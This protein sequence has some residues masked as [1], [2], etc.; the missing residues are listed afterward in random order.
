MKKI[1]LAL[2]ALLPALRSTAQVTIAYHENFETADSVVSSGLPTWQ[3]ETAYFSPPGVKSYR[4]TVGTATTPY[5]T[6]T[7]FSTVGNTFILFDFDQICK[8][9]FNDAATIE[10][11]NDNGVTW[12]QLTYNEYLGTAPFQ[13][14]GNRFASSAYAIWFP[15]NNYAT[16]FNTWWKHEQ[17]DCSSL[18]ANAAQCKIRFKLQDV[19]LNGNNH[20]YGWMLDNLVVTQSPSELTPPVITPLNPVFAGN[21]YNLGPYTVNDSITDASGIDSARLFWTLNNGPQQSMSMSNVSGNHWQG[22]IPAASDSD[23]ICYHVQAWDASPAANTAVWPNSGCTQ[24]VVHAGITFPFVDNFDGPTLF[25]DTNL[26][27]MSTSIWQLGTPN[28][29]ATNSA[30]TAPNAWDVDLNT[31]YN[32]NTNCA[33]VSPVFDFSSTVNAKMSFWQNRNCEGYWDGTRVEYTLDGGVTWNVL[34]TVG[35]PL[36]TNW[37]TNTALASSNLPGWDGNSNG[38]LKSEYKLSA[39]NNNANPVQ[40]RFVFTS[41]A[42]VTYDGFSIDDFQIIPAFPQDAATDMVI[43]PDMSSCLPVGTYPISVQISNPGSDTIVGPMDI[44]YVLD[45]GTPVTEQYLGTLLPSQVDTFTFA[46]QLTSSAGVHTLQ[47]YTALTGD[48][49]LAN[50]TITATYTTAPGVNVPYVNNF[51]NGPISLND[52]CTTNTSQ[53]RVQMVAGAGNNS[54]TG[55]AFDATS[56]LG[57]DFGTDTI[58]TSPMYIWNPAN[59]DQNEAN[60]RLIVNTAGYNSLVLEFDA[61]LLYQWANEYTNFRVKVNGQMI[62]PHMMPANA[63]TPYTTY[64]YM[65]SSFLP[66]PFLIIDFES[67]VTY[68]IA[69]Y[70]T[71]IYL[72][73]VHIYK[74]DSLDVGV[75]QITQPT[76][77]SIAASANT[78]A[79]KIRNFGISTITSIPVGYQVGVSAPVIET[80][81]GSL[82]PNATTT[83]TFTTTYSSPAG[84]YNLCTWTQLVGDTDTWNDSLCGSYFG[85][86][87]Y[88]APWSDNFDGPQHFAAVTTYTPSWELGNPQAPDIAGT[89][90]GPNAWEINLNGPYAFNSHEYLYSPFFNFQ[91][92]TNCELRFWQW[93]SCDTYYDGGR[94]EYSTDGG[95]TWL[96]LGIYMDPN[97]T[98]WYN[99]SWLSSANGQPGWSGNGGGYFQSK[100]NLSMFDNYPNPVQF[101]FVFTSDQ[102]N[103]GLDDGWAI[104]DFELYVP[105]DAGTNTITFGNAS[106]LPMPGNDNVKVNIKNAG[107]LPLNYVKATLKIDNTIVVTD[108]IPY[109][110]PLAPGASA[111]HT[112]SLPWTGATPGLHTVKTW[113]SVPDGLMDTNTSNDTTAWTVSVMDTFATYP[114]CNTFETG[115]GIPPLTTMNATRFVNAHNDWAQGTPAKNIMTSAHG[116]SSCWITNLNLNYLRND[117]AGLFLPVFT[118]DTIHCYHLEFYYRSLTEANHDGMQVEYSFDLG[119]TWQRLGMMGDLNWYT[120][121]NCPGLGAGYEPSMQGTSNGWILAQHDIRFSQAGQLIFRLRFGSD[122]GLESEGI[123]VD[124]ICF[125]Q[126]PPCV[127]SVED[128]QLGDGLAMDNYP[129]PAGTT[130]HVVYNL[131]DNGKVQIA[132]YDVV[133][134]RIQAMEAE[135]F[136]GENTW[137]VDVS[138]LTDGVYFY[139]LTF[140]TQKIVQKVVI[141]H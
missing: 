8:I 49:W 56:S 82:A 81:T 138:N 35:D 123:A 4:D 34:G 98:A 6:T 10:V 101:R 83:Y 41:D 90:S 67:K 21:V 39:F 80:W 79:V 9:E 51:E 86:P 17:F 134:Q 136:K 44:T 3:Y 61:E 42:S 75:T 72:D 128:H 20:N 33:L 26:T 137:T 118:V 29:G 46:T 140:G 91:N 132:L 13:S 15:G 135:Q 113:T 36:A 94:V 97:G 52:F 58:P 131:P 40:F 66:A 69:S 65:L 124:D 115:N 74:P 11:S 78:V 31:G 99:Q 122:N 12:T 130:S 25:Y 28:F 70:N 37:Y 95:N 100:Y 87:M 89:H 38:W 116:G 141:S 84:A 71:G 129:N 107:L 16:P 114:W 62:T 92:T 121:Q 102:Y 48:G 119:N 85:M 139:E 14:L 50:D 109:G 32:N 47:I 54:A 127:L 5:L 1:T 2:L 126:N 112:F 19:N 120:S 110:V 106:P 125:S 30:H 22:L 76:P 27:T 68:D 105:V 45:N 77:I 23:T 96:T 24:F 117:S 63:T 73:N 60:A 55:L 43:A 108:S 103:Y 18:L 93:Y 133:G 59:C 111:N 104:D 88:N 7:A 57:W 64:R 53:G